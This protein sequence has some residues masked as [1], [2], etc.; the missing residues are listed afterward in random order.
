MGINLLDTSNIYNTQDRSLGREIELMRSTRR[1]PPAE[2]L[3]LGT[4][5]RIAVAGVAGCQPVVV[6][7]PR[8]HRA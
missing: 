1:H 4:A 5:P 7:R 8:R 3:V 6:W 2:V